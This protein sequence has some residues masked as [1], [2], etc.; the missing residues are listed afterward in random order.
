VI[1]AVFK[2]TVAVWLGKTHLGE[3]N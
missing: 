3:M 2:T 1:Y